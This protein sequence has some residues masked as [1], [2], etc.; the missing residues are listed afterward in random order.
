MV[1]NIMSNS[2]DVG[3]SPLA[4]DSITPPV[5]KLPAAVSVEN[6]MPVP[7]PTAGVPLL[8]ACSLRTS[9]TE[10]VPEFST[11]SVTPT[12]CS[13]VSVTSPSAPRDTTAASLSSFRSLLM[14]TD[15]DASMSTIGAVISNS[16]SASMSS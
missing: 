5:S 9:V 12:L 11:L 14:F 15:V 4:D 13:C 6:S 1:L 3:V 16:A 8:C 10:F 2:S 7:I